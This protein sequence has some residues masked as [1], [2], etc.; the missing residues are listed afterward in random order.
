MF[1]CRTQT[2]GIKVAALL[3]RA[4]VA[5][6]DRNRN[7]VGILIHTLNGMALRAEL[8]WHVRNVFSELN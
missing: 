4:V 3:M 1:L 6:N 7:V 2:G 8:L 5:R